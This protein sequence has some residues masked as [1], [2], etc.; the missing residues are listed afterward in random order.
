M[1][2]QTLVEIAKAAISS[3]VVR[4]AQIERFL[5]TTSTGFG[6]SL[7][8]TRAGHSAFM[9]AAEGVGL[10]PNLNQVERLDQSGQPTEYIY[11]MF[12]AVPDGWREVE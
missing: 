4:E 3:I 6:L 2:K 8:A 5:G 9:K 12:V 11:S 7:R 1:G 10:V